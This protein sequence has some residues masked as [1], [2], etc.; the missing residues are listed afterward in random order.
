MRAVHCHA[1]VRPQASIGRHSNGIECMLALGCVPRA[2]ST[3]TDSGGDGP[4]EVLEFPA[5][6]ASDS[7]S[8]RLGSC[9]DT[10]YRRMLHAQLETLKRIF[11]VSLVKAAAASSLSCQW[12]LLSQRSHWVHSC[13]PLTILSP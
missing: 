4:I 10:V 12:Q 7:D 6:S 13:R 3:T 9:H 11:A 2:G 1:L 8:D 5:V